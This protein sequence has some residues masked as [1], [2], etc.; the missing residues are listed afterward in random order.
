MANL[1]F[2][3][4]IEEIKQRLD[5]VEIIGRYVQLRQVGTRWVGPCPF[6]QETKPSFN[7]SPDKGFFYCFGCQAAGDVIHFYQRING[8]EF[9]EAL[10][11]LAQEAG[12]SLNYNKVKKTSGGLKK[13]FYFLHRVAKEFFRQNLE[14]N[15][16]HV[17][18]KYLNQRKISPEVSSKFELG[19]SLDAW[20]GLE[21][22]FRTHKLDIEQA[23]LCGLLVKNEKGRIYDRF[24]NR[25]MFPI[26]D[27]QGRVVAFGARALGNDEPKYLN[28][29]ESVI[30]KKGEHLYGLYQAR[31]Y[32]IKTKSVILTEGYIDVLSLV[33]AGYANAC[34]ILGTS[35]TEQQVF[36]LAQCASKVILLLDGDSAGLKAA[37]RSAEMILS[38]GLECEVAVLP[39]GED[40]DSFLKQHGPEALQDILHR[41][42]SGLDYCLKMLRE[43]KSPGGQLQWVDNFLSRISDFKLKAYYLPKIAYGLGLSEQELRQAIQQKNYE[44]QAETLIQEFSSWDQDVLSLAVVFP[45]ETRILAQAGI[46]NFF[47][48]KQAKQLWE[49]LILPD[50][51]DS[52]LTEQERRFYVQVKLYFEEQIKK[53]KDNIVQEILKRLKEKKNKMERE[54]LLLALKNAQIKGNQEE[55]KR[56]LSL[57]QKSS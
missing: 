31:P 27:Y 57:L 13:Q 37:L 24:R 32:I 34:A 21:N 15:L 53:N 6:H 44:H 29:S 5:I 48:S 25:L 28:S 22:Y 30:Y 2:E 40:A 54:N 45:E 39:E 47:H 9:K 35:L 10:E 55:I 3:Q 52:I 42:S 56:I 43:N 46:S 26:L 16:G 33:Q 14:G 38:K 4:L 1:D 36:R 7:V 50:F 12:V 49:K 51:E 23:I 18:R 11:E 41:A 20:Q 17:A 19:Y 8:L